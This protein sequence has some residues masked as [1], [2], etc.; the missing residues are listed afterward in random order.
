[1]GLITEGN[2]HI[3]NIILEQRGIT[4]E[5]IEESL[6]VITEIIGG[7]EQVVA[8]PVALALYILDETAQDVA[9]AVATQADT[10]QLAGHIG[11]S[12]AAGIKMLQLWAMQHPW[13]NGDNDSL[14]TTEWDEEDPT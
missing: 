3:I 5:M 7:D 10:E 8:W 6:S 13:D 1:M 12:L 4:T 14:G 9:V 11:A 2:Q